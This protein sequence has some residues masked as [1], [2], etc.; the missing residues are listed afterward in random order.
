MKVLTEIYDYREMI[1]SLV[2]Q[3]LRSKY[4][5]SV[6]GFFW[7]FLNPL[8][9]LVVYTFVFS[10]LMKN[11]IEDYYLFLF[12]AFV[13][14]LFF[15]SSVTGGAR[16]ILD[17]KELVKKIYFPRQVLP[18]AYVTS[19]FINMV[20]SFVVVFGALILSR[21]GIALIP[22]LYLP[23][24]MLLEYIFALG[25]TMLVSALTVYLRDLEYIL[26]ILVMAWMYMTPIMYSETMVPQKYLI[27]FNLNPMSNI[28]QMYRKILYYKEAPAIE[29]MLQSLGIGII[30][31]VIGNIMFATIQKR[32]VEEL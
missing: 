12:V 15:S 31:L 32:F 30:F 2:R 25:I 5:G 9:Q 21:R 16:A 18:I 14:W 3:E 29:N 23:L 26:N 22:L 8:L 6:L 17:K 28:I 11:N 7:T 13:P 27:I 4:K 24:V 1:Y 20:L 10:A 19:A